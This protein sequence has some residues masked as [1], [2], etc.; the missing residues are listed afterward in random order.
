MSIDT[1]L[2][3]QIL[4]EVGDPNGT[5]QPLL[6]TLW[7]IYKDTFTQS[8]LLGGLYVKRAALDVR[9]AEEQQSNDFTVAQDVKDMQSVRFDHAKEMRD[10]THAEIVRIEA[11]ARGSR[12][13]ASGALTTVEPVTPAYGPDATDPRYTGSPYTRSRTW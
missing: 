8:K 10:A 4:A 3:D 11:Q 5:I 9:M 7:T 12:V 13:P 1:D 2:L 6:P